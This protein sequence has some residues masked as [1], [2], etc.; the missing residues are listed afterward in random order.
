MRDT[1][2][3]LDDEALTARL[4]ERKTELDDALDDTVF[5]GM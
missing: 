1:L 4:R 5:E 2:W 3:R